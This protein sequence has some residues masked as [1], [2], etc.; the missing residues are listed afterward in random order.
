MRCVPISEN[1][2]HADHA[3]HS[4]MRPVGVEPTKLNV[5]NVA[6]LP[7]VHGRTRSDLRRTYCTPPSQ[8]DRFDIAHS[9]FIVLTH[10]IYHHHA[11]IRAGDFPRQGSGARS[12][13]LKAI[14]HHRSVLYTLW[15]CTHDQSTLTSVLR[16]TTVDPGR[17]EL[18]SDMVPR[19]P[20]S[21][22][23]NHSRAR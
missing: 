21:R 8:I 18:P 23:R 14:D 10:R 12:G 2:Q 15:V 22:R 13:G 5:L 1:L 7:F 17:F 4:S 3:Q 6:T 20:S 19:G 11:H 16:N 9:S